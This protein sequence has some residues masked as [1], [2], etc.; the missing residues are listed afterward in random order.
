LSR[1]VK[2]LF[3]MNASPSNLAYLVFGETF[4]GVING[5]VLDWLKLLQKQSPEMNVTLVVLLSPRQYFSNRK[6]L[7]QRYL[8]SL[9]LPML[10]IKRFWKLNLLI[11]WL[12][13]K[14]KRY[15]TVICR[16]P[17]ATSLMNRIRGKQSDFKVVYDGRGARSAELKEYAPMH[18]LKET[19]PEIEKHAVLSSDYRIAVSQGLVSHWMSTFGYKEQAHIVISCTLSYTFDKPVDNSVADPALRE[20]LG[21]NTDDLIFVFAGGNAMWQQSALIEVFLEWLLSKPNHRILF[22]SKESAFTRFFSER[23]PTSIAQKWLSVEDVKK[24]MSV[25]DY[26][27]LIRNED[28]TNAVA[29]PVKFAEYL[30]SGLKV[31]CSQGL[32]D[33][34]Q[35][36]N[37]HQAGIVIGNSMDFNE[38]SIEKPTMSERRRMGQLAAAHFSKSSPMIQALQW[39]DRPAPQKVHTAS[40]GS[41]LKR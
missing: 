34:S 41:H 19:M 31:I 9:C 24:W 1:T 30:A 33:Y 38:L 14:L 35:F 26:G 4:S 20:E 21:W 22:L 36:V 13:Q 12:V 6:L 16:G 7:K 3:H 23:Y 15:D 25:G 37:K 11:L 28:T 8:R 2:Q 5:Q 39:A 10:P 17:Q 29:A 27:L 32:G 18:P 40:W